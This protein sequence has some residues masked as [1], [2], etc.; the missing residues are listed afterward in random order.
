MYKVVRILV[1]LVLL[2][3]LL[4]TGCARTEIATAESGRQTMAGPGKALAELARLQSSD[5]PDAPRVPRL[6]PKAQGAEDAAESPAAG[7]NPILE[8]AFDGNETISVDQLLPYVR[9]RAGRPAAPA[10]IRQDVEK[11]LATRWFVSVRDELRDTPRG[12]ILVFHVVERPIVREVIYRGNK[13]IKTKDLEALSGLRKGSGMDP[14]LNQ[15]IARRIEEHYQSK[16]YTFAHVELAEGGAA[17]DRRVVFEIDE[18]K[19]VVVTSI[20]IEGNR[21]VGDARLKTQ[22]QTKQRH[23]WLFGGRYDPRTVDAD[24]QRLQSYYQGLG[25]FDVRVTPERRADA[26]DPSRIAV[27]FYI[28]EGQRYHVR[29]IK[30]EGNDRISEQQLRADLALKPGDEF[31]Q[32]KLRKDVERIQGMYGAL[33]HYYASIN[34]EPVFEEKEGILDLVY[35]INER[36]P[37]HVRYVNVIIKG[38]NPRTQERV[39]RNL[40]K[41]RPG[42]LLDPAKIHRSE[43][44]L[45]ASQL[46]ENDP[47]TGGPHIEVVEPG[48]EHRPP[49]ITQARGQSGDPLA[50]QGDPFDPYSSPPDL[51][52]PGQAD[53]NVI[54]SEAQT[55]RFMVG[56]GIDSSNSL[57]G[58]IVLHERNFDITRWPGSFGEILDGTAFRGAGQEFRLEALPGSRV[59]RYIASFREPYL[60]DT[61]ISFGVSGYYFQRFFVDW[62]EERLGGRFSL[63]RAIT[64]EIAINVSL[65]LESVTISNPDVPTPPDLAAVV[66]DNFLGVGRIALSHDTR[67]SPFMPTEGHF[68]EIAY[69]QGFGD[70]TFPRGTVE[71]RQYYT[72]RERPDGTGQQVLGLRALAGVTGSNT[73]LFDRFFAG[74]FQTLR[75]FDYRGASPRVFNVRVGG[76]FELL[77]S[78]EYQ[79]PLTADDALRAV[80]F[81]DAGTVEESVKITAE[82]FR[83]ALGAG[84]RVQI[85][86]M[87]PA[88]IAL[89]FAVP[90][91]HADG[92]DIEIFSFW[93]GFF[94]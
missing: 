78:A 29:D 74:G 85:P 68:A 61:P 80:F 65:Q 36:D 34:P 25:F 12:Q 54:A 1:P 93:I 15:R 39:V 69:E 59:S 77:A 41:I 30:F 48:L 60:F 24:V 57:V 55:G 9:S 44:V 62:D 7:R 94:R 86:L 56:A 67:D 45:K 84:L 2:V 35:S 51:P 83:V 53:I 10:L 66:G 14:A 89:D 76:D 4:A 52:P 58:S 75:G 18:G 11:L 50:P 90:V 5:K 31:S 27:A 88:P 92:D 37:M 22:L 13:K 82:D 16:G 40:V 32:H 63:G 8:V 33:G 26:D 64:D 49:S 47:I 73:P 43:Q 23:F 21:F 72:I 46:F 79:F 70:F 71:G 81:V 42:D 38:K 17:D 19:K 87:G 6:L 28:E 91:A 20:R 3:P